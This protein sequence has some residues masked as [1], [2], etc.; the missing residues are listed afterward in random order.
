MR[1]NLFQL[2]QFMLHSRGTSEWKIDC[3]EGLVDE[4]LQMLA[5][6]VSKHFK[7]C[8][9][10]G[11]PE[12]G[13]KFADALR[14]YA[15]TNAKDPILIVDDVLTTGASMSAAKREFGE[16]VIGVVIFSRGDSLDWV[17]PIFQTGLL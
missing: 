10:V 8:H 12:G 4:D 9:V 14:P 1:K 13:L 5:H 2:G 17:T 6:V 3:E 11:V 16:N 15:T 7:F